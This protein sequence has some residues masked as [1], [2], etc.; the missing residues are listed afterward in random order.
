MVP[1]NTAINEV[2][3]FLLS[4]EMVTRVLDSENSGEG[5]VKIDTFSSEGIEFDDA[6]LKSFYCVI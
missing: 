4:N 5:G 6:I 3:T 1:D 2:P